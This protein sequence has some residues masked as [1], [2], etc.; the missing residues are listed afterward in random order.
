MLEVLNKASNSFILWTLNIIPQNNI[1]SS[2]YQ[3][4]LLYKVKGQYHLLDFLLIN[5]FQIQNMNHIQYLFNM[6]QSIEKPYPINPN[7]KFHQLINYYLYFYF[8]QCK[9]L[10]Y[11][12][13]IINPRIQINIYYKLN[14][15]YLFLKFNPFNTLKNYL[16]KAIQ[17]PL[18]NIINYYLYYPIIKIKKRFFLTYSPPFYN[19]YYILYL[20]TL[21]V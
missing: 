21:N 10:H 20:F 12:I 7:H 5:K 2:F 19:F 15:S 6:S 13:H 1:N 4:L 18:Q 8:P 3:N 16:L 11:H 17:I 14:R 9:F